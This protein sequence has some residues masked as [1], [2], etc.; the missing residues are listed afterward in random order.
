MRKVDVADGAHR[1]CKYPKCYYYKKEAKKYCCVACSCD[2]YDYKRLGLGRKGVRNG[3][4][5]SFC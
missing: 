5:Q 3:Y 4:S 2:H 1:T